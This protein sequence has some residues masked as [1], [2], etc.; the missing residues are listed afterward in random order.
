[1]KSGKQG[2]YG[3]TRSKISR[4]AAS[5]KTTEWHHD[6]TSVAYRALHFT[7]ARDQ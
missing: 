4:A 5:L 6:L 3:N 2:R 1:M 7:V